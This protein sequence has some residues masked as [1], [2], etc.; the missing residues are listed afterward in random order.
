[1]ITL[2]AFSYTSQLILLIVLQKPFLDEVSQL[3]DDVSSVLPAADSLEQFLMELIK[4]VTDDDDARRDFEQQL[5]PYQVSTCWK[6]S[7]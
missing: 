7:S 3:T 4:S 6:L 2:C 5:T 1:M